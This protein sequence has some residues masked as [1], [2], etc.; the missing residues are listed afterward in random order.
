[1]RDA[2]R[3]KERW[4]GRRTPT[5]D[6]STDLRDLPLAN[7]RAHDRRAFIAVERGERCAP[8]PQRGEVAANDVRKQSPERTAGIVHQRRPF[9]GVVACE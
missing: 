2:A 4:K 6:P 8:S 5:Q 3:D 1:M 7:S 9:L